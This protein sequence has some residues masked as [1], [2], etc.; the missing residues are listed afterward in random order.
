MRILYYSIAILMITGLLYFIFSNIPHQV[1]MPWHQQSSI[2]YR[3]EQ[4]DSGFGL[5]QAEAIAFAEQAA[6]IWEK[7]TG[8]AYFHY[9][10]KAKLAIVF[11]YDERQ[12]NSQQ[13][14]LQLTQIEQNQQ[15]WLVQ[16][17]QVNQNKLKLQ[18]EKKLIEQQKQ[19]LNLAYQQYQQASQISQRNLSHLQQQYQ[20]LLKQ[21]QQLDQRIM[22]FNQAI[23][24]LNQQVDALN[25][26]NH[27]IESKVSRFN[28]SLPAKVFDKGS[29]NGQQITIYEFRSPQDLVL[30]LAHEFGHALGL[31]HSNDPKALMYY[32]MKDQDMENFQLTPSDL[33]LLNSKD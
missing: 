20:D 33:A 18:T 23:Q 22:I 6:K 4:P 32:L 17:E 8:Q 28:Q 16:R 24:N 25:Q 29:F 26:L 7:G 19:S 13:R 15:D 5:T 14:Q 30:T 9:D 3:V 12:Q 27:Q 31:S 21:S 1:K 2:A 11:V 10:P